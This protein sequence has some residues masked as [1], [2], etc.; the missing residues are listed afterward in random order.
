MDTGRTNDFIFQ[1]R[2]KKSQMKWRLSPPTCPSSEMCCSYSCVPSSLCVVERP[3]SDAP[4]LREQLLILLSSF[5]TSSR[6]RRKPTE[7]KQTFFREQTDLSQSHQPERRREEKE[8]WWCDAGRCPSALRR[9]HRVP[10]PLVKSNWM[11]FKTF[12]RPQ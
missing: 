1:G 9:S 11:L 6:K 2:M 12:L 5:R 8:V 10:A 7:Q 4:L 3:W